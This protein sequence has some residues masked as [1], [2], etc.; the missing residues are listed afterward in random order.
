MTIPP[1]QIAALPADATLS[2][3][4][5]LT[6][7]DR[8]LAATGGKYAALALVAQRHKIPISRALSR[9]HRLGLAVT[10]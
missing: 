3:P 7:L 1:G 10:R 4:D 8:D 9:W 2:Q 5:D 6:P